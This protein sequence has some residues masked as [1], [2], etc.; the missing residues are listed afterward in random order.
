MA[1]TQVNVDLR[2]TMEKSC[3][4]GWEI[5]AGC[6]QISREYQAGS[7][8]F[9]SGDTT[10]GLL[11]IKC[12]GCGSPTQSRQVSIVRKLRQDDTLKKF[13]IDAVGCSSVGRML[14]YS[15]MREAPG[16]PTSTEKLGV[17]YT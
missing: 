16:S 9:S 5:R 3:P 13:G 7:F 15:R 1:N 12:K 6:F 11:I 2:V 8:G 14:V 4:R 10:D 17:A